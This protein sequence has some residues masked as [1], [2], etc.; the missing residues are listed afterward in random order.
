MKR[1]SLAPPANRIASIRE[2]QHL[3]RVR[4][5]DIL[6]G[7]GLAVV[8]A[9]AFALLI[10]VDLG[11][12]GVIAGMS[13]RSF[14]ASCGDAG[15]AA[16][17]G[18]GIVLVGLLALN[19]V[20]AR[21]LAPSST[22]T[23]LV[24]VMLVCAA[25]F[26]LMGLLPGGSVGSY[27]LD[28][29]L[30][31]LGR[32]APLGVGA[33]ELLDSLFGLDCA[34]PLQ[35]VSALD[36][37]HDRYTSGMDGN[38]PS[39]GLASSLLIN[40]A[41]AAAWNAVLAVL[42]P[43]ALLVRLF[44]RGAA[45]G[46]VVARGAERTIVV[47][48]AAS[49][50][51]IFL[52]IP[53]WVALSDNPGPVAE[54]VLNLLWIGPLV[55]VLDMARVR[56][57]A[58]DG[59][60][61]AVAAD[62][63][64]PDAAPPPALV[65][66][67][68]QRAVQAELGKAVLLRF[69]MDPGDAAP[70]A[71]PPVAPPTEP[72]FLTFREQALTPAL[73]GALADEMSHGVLDLG[74]SLLVIC[75]AESQAEVRQRLHRAMAGQDG[76]MQIGWMTELA[77]REA[78]NAAPR[79]DKARSSAD[80]VI[81]D[82][83]GL[84]ELLRGGDSFEQFMTRLGGVLIL[85]AHALDIGLVRAS[86]NRLLAFVAAP[87]ALSVIVQAERRHGLHDD[88]VGNLPML[89]AIDRRSVVAGMDFASHRAH[90]MMLIDNPSSARIDNTR[91]SWPPYLRALLAVHKAVPA[92]GAAMVNRDLRFSRQ[93]VARAVEP[94]LR[95]GGETGMAAWVSK[96]PAVQIGPP[97]GAAPV[98]VID[99]R[100][101]L[102]DALVS[103]MAEE[104]APEALTLVTVGGYPTSRFLLDQVQAQVKPARNAGDLRQ[105][106]ASIH[107]RFGSI[108]P[109]PRDGPAE[110][111]LM[112][113]REL[114]AAQRE[115][116]W[117]SQRRLRELWSSANP[118]I[119]AQL[120]ITVSSAGLKQL[121]KVAAS[122]V[123]QDNQIDSRRDSDLTRQFNLRGPA[124]QG[125]LALDML[126]VHIGAPVERFLPRADHGLSYAEGTRLVVG[127]M[128]RRVVS[129]SPQ[130]RTV[131]L[132]T[133]DATPVRGLDFV[134]DYA[135]PALEGVGDFAAEAHVIRAEVHQ[136]H[137]RAIGYVP[138]ARRTREALEWGADAAPFSDT[139]SPRVIPCQVDN[140]LRL[141]RV[142]CLSLLTEAGAAP[143]PRARGPGAPGAPQTVAPRVAFTLA[144]T[145]SDV[146][147][148]LF[149]MQAHRLAV[150]HLPLMPG[151]DRLRDP[152]PG[153]QDRV[154]G[155]AL[156]RQ[157]RLIPFSDDGWLDAGRSGPEVQRR[158]AERGRSFATEF[159]RKAR[160]RPGDPVS[161]A[162]LTLMLIE[163]SDHDL[164]VARAFSNAFDSRVLPFWQE[165]LDWCAARPVGAP[166]HP[167]GFGTG[168]VPDVFDFAEASRIVSAMR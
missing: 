70:V 4:L 154:L 143:P 61:P 29:M 110:L 13:G 124:A 86:F 91:A 164:G 81:T 14:K 118:A 31:D 32:I 120:H 109:D 78:G 5:V 102:A 74:G 57:F 149:P 157:P 106:L 79:T 25:P 141:R 33:F 42:V 161:D 130:A 159:M 107:D 54:A 105:A 134:R 52:G 53:V 2:M 135:S 121:F 59:A 122:T 73:F 153:P 117:V 23:S 133:A 50:L 48:L 96:L 30:T 88:T 51:L 1:P 27:N 7:T 104:T 76:D 87:G 158:L 108:M 28:Q 119:L 103:G 44:R 94:V 26:A 167:Y 18:I 84:E 77:H 163:D 137:E 123:L 85:H 67:E 64:R 47:W 156:R 160:P 34:A 138:F 36:R 69:Q 100:W 63:D 72:G 49:A 65:L 66:A 131:R 40:L 80:I 146:V 136:P 148:T 140:P 155:Y 22:L 166:G 112:T 20:L 16:S 71:A 132:E 125:A 62:A 68:A 9:F 114:D 12:L 38:W 162:R 75:P 95:H 129:V 127:G 152:Q 90:G 165:Y 82:P 147:A 116:T 97:E 145:L 19:M 37:L 55:L 58:P 168:D 115:K 39:H 46:P 113:V 60:A 99:D 17:G 83:E 10:L 98:G 128:V 144:A 11:G 139:G 21:L 24:F 6:G 3:T 56:L 150:V 142:A 15:T 8:L 151:Q 45:A 111:M 41:L 126:R 89:S 35:P 101:N 92:A 93:A 43:I